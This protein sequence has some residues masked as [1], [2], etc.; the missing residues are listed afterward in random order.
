MTTEEFAE[1]LADMK[2]HYWKVTSNRN[3]HQ[4]YGEL[5]Q[6]VYKPKKTKR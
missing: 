4:K 1:M 2:Q 5:D 6:Y 3:K